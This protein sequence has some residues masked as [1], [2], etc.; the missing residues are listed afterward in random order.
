M[1]LQIFEDKIADSHRN[2]GWIFSA[3]IC[4]LI[5]VNLREKIAMIIN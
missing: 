2:Y 3:E 4:V 5:S 1:F